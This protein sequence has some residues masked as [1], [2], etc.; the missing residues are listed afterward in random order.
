MDNMQFDLLALLPE[1]V[2]LGM[3]MFILLLDLFILPQNRSMIYGLS[4][5][6]LFAAAF[7][8]FKTHTPAVGFAFSHMFIDDTLSDVIKLMMYLSTSLILVYTRKYLQDRNLYRGEFYAMVLFGLLGMMIMV[9]GH[10]LLTIYIGLELLSLCL[11]SLVAF[12]RDNP[13]ASESA[14]K[15]FVLGALASG[16]LL[17]GM[18]MLYGMTGSLDVSDIA[19]NIMQQHKSPVLIMGL[20]FVVAGIAFKFG[21]VP[22]QMW[23]PDVYQGSPTPMTLLIGSVPKLAAY[24]MTVR[25]L[26]QGLHPLA[27]DWQDMLVLMAVLSIIIG[28]F[29]AIVQTNLKRMLAYS[30]ISNVGFIMFGMM[31]ANANG[32]ASS[33]FYIAA[34]VLMSI[35]G[36]GI[37]LLLSRKGFEADEINDLKGLNQRHPWYAFLMLIVMFSMAG[38]PPTVG[39]YAK[40]T[41]LQA[42][43]QAGFTWQVVLAVLMAT[44]GA[45]YYLNIVRK[46]YF[47]EAVDHA[48]LTAPLDM[49]LVLSVQTLALLGLGLFPE[50]LLSVCGHSLL[51]S[52]Q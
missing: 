49:R 17:Y 52:L 42:A 40:F 50:I 24:A 8:T 21:A 29:S 4:Q 10:N 12:D 33:F 3:A 7:F 34:Y 1:L 22:F 48:P 25:L 19:N 14:M 35:S 37:I 39:F 51:I 5:F 15:Y 20:V 23:V 44:I 11:Y 38:I 46:M 28:N 2:V 18:S 32:F 47:D 36:F 41:V 30:T 43:W 27:L 16:M 31:S 26:V 6:T 9:S 13:K 45:F